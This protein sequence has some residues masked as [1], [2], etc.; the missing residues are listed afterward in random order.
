MKD[1]ESFIPQG[2]K[3]IKLLSNSKYKDKRFIKVKEIKKE[4][5]SKEFLLVDLLTKQESLKEIMAV[6]KNRSYWLLVSWYNPYISNELCDYAVYYAN[7]LGESCSL[8]EAKY[9]IVT[10]I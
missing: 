10:N 4:T 5:Y 7:D 6:L 1:F 9:T 3:K 2:M 8:S